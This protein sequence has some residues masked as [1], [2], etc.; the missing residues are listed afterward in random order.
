MRPNRA[1]LVIDC[2]KGLHFMAK[3]VELQNMNLI[4]GLGL[5]G[6][7]HM[8][9]ITI[10]F[11][12]E[13]YD[14]FQKSYCFKNLKAIIYLFIFLKWIMPIYLALGPPV[15]LYFGPPCPKV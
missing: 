11:E 10:M 5:G 14:Y 6:P 9:T 4:A 1:L 13:I 8:C 12:V 15:R 7:R 3:C 2:K